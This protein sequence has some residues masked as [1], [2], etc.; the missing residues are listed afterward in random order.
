MQV[1]EALEDYQYA[2][3]EYAPKTQAM[4]VAR[5]KQFASWCEQ[6][7]IQL[8]TLKSTDVSRF[9]ETVRTRKN[10]RSGKPLSSYTLHGYAATIKAFLNWAAKDDLLSEKVPARI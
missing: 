4:N 7:T 8:E 2:I 3:L 6:Q 5:L 10:P 9:L 1:R